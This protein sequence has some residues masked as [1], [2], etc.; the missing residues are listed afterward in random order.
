M[1]ALTISRE[2]AAIQ[3][4]TRRLA[5]WSLLIHAAGAVL[6][7]VSAGNHRP[8]V[9][10]DTVITE[11]T[12]LDELAPTP[13][14][15][16]EA[17]TRPASAPVIAT[18]PEPV[19]L[20]PERGTSVAVVQQRLAALRQK[21]NDLPDIPAAATA[22]STPRIATVGSLVPARPAAA[23]DLTRQAGTASA[24]PAELTK[25]R[26]SVVAAAVTTL[27]VDHP[28]EST[29]PAAEILPGISLAGEVSNRTLVAYTTP[30]YPDWA[31]RDG[32]EVSVRLY[33]TVLP[34][35]RVKENILIEHTSGY[36][37]FDRRARNA[38][39][40]WRFDPLQT[41]SGDEQWGRIEFKYRLRQAG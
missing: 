29:V 2:I 22:R 5:L 19:P 16:A 3:E 31:K 37:D 7:L 25:T 38:L 4:K 26:P 39:I 13:L 34:D 21:Q 17:E 24:V 28:S 12:W 14:V 30:E 27:S 36:D 10:E 1:D 40:A 33:F 6:F 32:V 41:G 15:V 18:E 23:Q 8:D 35:G 9:T 20:I 11:I